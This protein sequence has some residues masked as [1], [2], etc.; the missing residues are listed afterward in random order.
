MY[1]NVNTISIPDIIFEY[2]HTKTNW[3]TMKD[4]VESNL[5]VTHMLDKESDLPLFALVEKGESENME[6]AYSL[7]SIEY[8]N[9][10][11]TNNTKKM[12]IT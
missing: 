9:M 12:R 2:A 4:I 7:L 8:S 10:F 1:A 5:N 3:I 6:V 11:T